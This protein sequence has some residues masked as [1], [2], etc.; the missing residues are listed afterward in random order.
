M[1]GY[2]HWFL[3]VR[4]VLRSLAN[5]ARNNDGSAMC[6]VHNRSGTL[7]SN[8]PIREICDWRLSRVQV[9]SR[10]YGQ[11]L[12]ASPHIAVNNRGDVVPVARSGEPRQPTPDGQQD[13]ARG[14]IGFALVGEVALDRRARS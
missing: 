8:G 7:D 3:T 12:G 6:A 11:P 14:L 1:D 2:A 10:S 4:A 13:V 9:K 5:Q